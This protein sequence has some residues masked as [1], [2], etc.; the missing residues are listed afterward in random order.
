MNISLTNCSSNIIIGGYFGSYARATQIEN[1]DIDFAFF[2]KDFKK[3][4]HFTFNDEIKT[5]KKD[6][7][8]LP[9]SLLSLPII[10][11]KSVTMFLDLQFIFNPTNI[12]P[13]PFF[14]EKLFI[15][16]LELERLKNIS[17]FANKKVDSLYLKKMPGGRRT[18][19]ELIW[20]DKILLRKN[21]PSLYNK[22]HITTYLQKIKNIYT[23]KEM[24][25]LS[26]ELDFFILQQINT[27]T[28]IDSTSRGDVLLQTLNRSIFEAF[29]S[30]NANLLEKLFVLALE[31]KTMQNW[32]I[33]YALASNPNITFNIAKTIVSLTSNSY[34]VYEF[35]KGLLQN[36][37]LKEKNYF[38]VLLKKLQNDSN[39]LV[40]TYSSILLDNNYLDSL[41]EEIRIFLKKN[42]SHIL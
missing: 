25:K 23:K 28:G 9:I 13:S 8:I 1:S 22:K 36:K 35:K 6:F 17:I 20:L 33:I 34:F 7:F 40:R 10:N 4:I 37:S 18:L 21:I 16:F 3:P 12:K 42:I 31:E 5:L 2:V 32:L 29:I 30:N 11:P 14:D 26:D 39:S 38:N 24:N 15:A 41:P 19:D 27:I